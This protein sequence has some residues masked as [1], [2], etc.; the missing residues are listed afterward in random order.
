MTETDIEIYLNG[1]H[2]E[3]V[4]GKVGPEDMARENGLNYRGIDFGWTSRKIA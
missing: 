4:T 1:S 3:Y 2:V